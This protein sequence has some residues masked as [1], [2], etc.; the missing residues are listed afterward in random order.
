[1]HQVFYLTVAEAMEYVKV[2]D[3]L[4]LITYI[5]KFL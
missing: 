2:N 1:M 3:T 5:F 4:E